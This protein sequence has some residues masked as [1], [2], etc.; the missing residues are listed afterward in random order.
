MQGHNDTYTWGPDAKLT[1]EGL[2]QVH[3]TRDAW[4]REI[5]AGIP[6]PESHHVSP[7]S[8]SLSTQLE[9]WGPVKPPPVANELLRETLGLHFGDQRSAASALRKIYPEIDFPPH[10][11]PEDDPLWTHLRE[12]LSGRNAR[13]KHALDQIMLNDRNTYISM[14]SHSGVINSTLVA[15]GHRP[16]NLQTAGMIPVVVR[17]ERDVE[18]ESGGRIW[19]QPVTPS[20]Q[21]TGPGPEVVERSV[22]PG[23]PPVKVSGR[24]ENG[25]GIWPFS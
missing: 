7:L 22:C 15:L 25:M 17:V 1:P 10:M 2:S 4:R 19:W 23:Y 16:Y 8:R 9:T 14:T 20:R 18:R 13:I 21:N 5:R 3:H 12:S 24:Y 6:K 11:M